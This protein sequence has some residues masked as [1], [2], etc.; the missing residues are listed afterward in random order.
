[1]YNCHR[2]S[3]V[4]TE[5]AASKSSNAKKMRPWRSST[6]T[7][8]GSFRKAALPQ[9]PKNGRNK[10]RQLLGKAG[11][12]YIYKHGPEPCLT[13]KPMPQWDT[14]SFSTNLQ[15]WL[16]FNHLLKKH[17]KKIWNL[18]RL[19][20]LNACCHQPSIIYA[21][22]RFEWSTDVAP[23][24]CWMGWNPCHFVVVPQPSTESKKTPKPN[25]SADQVD[26]ILD[27]SSI[28]LYC[29]FIVLSFKEIIPFF[30]KLL[31]FFHLR[32][33][34]LPRSTFF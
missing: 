3:L 33:L 19:Q 28:V 18:W 25:T 31:W 2:F 30:P 4:T 11:H 1:M 8:L 21:A 34:K 24:L 20:S 23:F 29:S 6:L 32:L 7:L 10:N 5:L 22:A 13:G 15:G 26:M 9:T 17:F 14:M 16:Q 27:R 12:I